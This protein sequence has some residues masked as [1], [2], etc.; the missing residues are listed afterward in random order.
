MVTGAVNSQVFYVDSC[1][2]LLWI[3]GPRARRA[4]FF[5]LRERLRGVRVYG[6]ASSIFTVCVLGVAA[7][8]VVWQVTGRASLSLSSEPFAGSA[9]P[10]S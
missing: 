10:Q 2:A 8:V 1:G 6:A 9:T 7:I 4:F 3:K 5:Y